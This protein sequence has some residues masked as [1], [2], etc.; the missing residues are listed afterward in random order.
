SAVAVAPLAF[1]CAL[2]RADDQ[3][4]PTEREKALE[5]K[6]E[7]MQKQID[8]LNRRMSD[9]ASRAGDELSARVDE[10]EKLKK[11][12]KDGLFAYWGKGI[13]M[14]SANGRFKLKIGGRVQNDWSWF[15]HTSDLEGVTGT[16]IEAG[17]E[18]R[19]ARLYVGGTIYENVDFMNEWDF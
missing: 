19:R 7:E 6:L 18:F 2:A 10:L 4:A 5:K 12:D 15:A 16:Q 1:F 8:E 3:A 9:G 13:R 17:E 14:D 11:K